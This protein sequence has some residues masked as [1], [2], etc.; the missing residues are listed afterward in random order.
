[1]ADTAPVAFGAIA[2]PITT[3]GEVTGLPVNHLSQMV[4]R[5]TPFL[6]LLLPFVLVYM[7]DGRRGLRESW[8]AAL[9]AGL[10][11][12]VLQ[13]AMSN[14][15]SMQLTDIV[16]SLGSVAALIMFLRVWSPQAPLAPAG[17]SRSRPAIAG[18]ATWPSRSR[19]RGA[20]RTTSH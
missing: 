12:A 6:A 17:L 16:A 19:S 2:I 11:F 15:V 1:V 18:A 14:Y 9:V 8:P 7:I 20:P 3:L 4:G 13:F 10:T 5:Q